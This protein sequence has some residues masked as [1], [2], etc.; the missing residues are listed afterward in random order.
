MAFSYDLNTDAGK[1]RLLIPDSNAT[2]Y[3][4]EDDEIAAFLALESGIRRAAALGLETIARNEAMVL[5]VIQILDLRTDGA[6]VARE[7]RLQAAELRKQAEDA[8]LADGGGFE[9]AEWVVDDFTYRQHL[10]NAILRGA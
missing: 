3:I 1:V 4:F 2:S 7:L 10:N 8:D 9:I 5:K 6:A